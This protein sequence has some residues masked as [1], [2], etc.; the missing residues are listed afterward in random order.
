MKLTA[1]GT[2][3]LAMVIAM[4]LLASCVSKKKY[5]EALTRAAAEKS[6]LESEIQS[7]QADNDKL[8]AD[9]EQLQKNLNMSSEEIKRLSEE[10]KANNAKIAALQNSIKEAFSTYNPQDVVVEERNGKLYIVMANKILYKSGSADLADGSQEIIS[11]LATVINNNPGLNI[12]IE[13][14]TDNEP[15]KVNK[16]KYADNWGLSVAR[17]TNVVRALE[18]AGVSPARLIAS[19]KGDTQPIADNA[20]EAGRDTN[21]RTEFVVLPKTDGL[22][23]MYKSNFSETG[24]GMK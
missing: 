17:S 2:R 20:T 24:S 12:L 1:I 8:K 14:H 4:S 18:K 23:R 11:K 19:G 15:V 13:G 22:Y 9:S 16:N 7:L 3:M 6:A 5:Q 21:R 10:I